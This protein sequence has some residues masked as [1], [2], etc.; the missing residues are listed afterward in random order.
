MKLKRE[1]KSL[2]HEELK[3]YIQG[4]GQTAFRVKQIEQWLYRK[5][6]D[7]F[8]EMTNIPKGL[9]EKLDEEFSLYNPKVIARQVSAD[10]TRKY[11]LQFFDGVNVETVGIPAENGKHLTVCFSTQAGCNM[12]CIFCAT[13]LSGLIR[14]LNIGEIITQIHIV[15]QDFGT[16]VSNVVAMG[17]GEPFANYDTLLQALRYMN[18]KD[19]LEIG[20]RHITVSSCG[21]IQGVKKFTAE[22]Q[23]FTLAISLHSAVQK[24]RDVL[25]PNLK[26]QKLTD[27][28]QALKEYGEITK[29]RPS[30]EYVLIKGV[31]DDETHLN[32]LVEFCKGMLAHVNLIPLNPVL[33]EN[34]KNSSAG[35]KVNLLP[36]RKAKYFEST[37][38]GSH[39]EVSI[40]N[41][42]GA[43]IDGACGQLQQKAII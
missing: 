39:I 8:A 31:N 10:G 18:S 6:V 26:T 5:N 16:R 43:D 1:I 2:T 34:S 33:C 12:G 40:R 19:G 20:A 25:M 41:S 15:E 23:Q 38:K 21:I 37:L 13:G 11:L 9:Q 30:L 14:N 3:D 4:L 7:S 35:A 36:S 17:Q 28:K 24:T 32:A 22:P 42:R 27:L 29:R